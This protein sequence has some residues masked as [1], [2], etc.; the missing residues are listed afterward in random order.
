MRKSTRKQLR[1]YV[2]SSQ[3]MFGQN[4]HGFLSDGKWV[5]NEDNATL[6]NSANYAVEQAKSHRV[7][8]SVMYSFVRISIEF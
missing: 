5:E 3:D 7:N 2:A 4:Q 6:F 1:K 8:D